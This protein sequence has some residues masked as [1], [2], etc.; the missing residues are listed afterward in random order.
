MACRPLHAFSDENFDSD[1]R[2][3]FCKGY[4][5]TTP[6]GKFHMDLTERPPHNLSVAALQRYLHKM[7]FEVISQVVLRRSL[8]G[9][10]TGFLQ[11]DYRRCFLDI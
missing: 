5:I 3:D 11:N 2:R 9:A 7:F 10:S 1:L 6:E 8:L 4:E